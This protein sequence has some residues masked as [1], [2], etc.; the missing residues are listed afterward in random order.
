MDN[1]YIKL[2]K[3]HVIGNVS[4]MLDTESSEIHS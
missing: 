4:K 3:R 2:L 1:A